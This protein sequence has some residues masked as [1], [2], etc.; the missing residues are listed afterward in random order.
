MSKEREALLKPEKAGEFL[1]FSEGWL[2]KLRMRG[3]GPK[4]VKLGRK[5]RYVRADLDAWI[6]ASRLSSTSEVG[7]RHD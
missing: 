7:A 2:A 5:V 4:Y 3:T 1:G 6:A